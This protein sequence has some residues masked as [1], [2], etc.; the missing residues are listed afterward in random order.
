MQFSRKSEIAYSRVLASKHLV[1]GCQN[2]VRSV[3]HLR[4]GKAI[5]RRTSAH[6]GIYLCFLAASFRVSIICFACTK[7]PP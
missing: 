4:A 6:V 5:Q 1:S 3:H 2:H 7:E